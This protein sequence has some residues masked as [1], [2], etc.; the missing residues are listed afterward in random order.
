[1]RTHG[2]CLSEPGLSLVV[3]R[4]AGICI[5]LQ[6]KTRLFSRLSSMPWCKHTVFS[7][8]THLLV[9]F[10]AMGASPNHNVLSHKQ[11]LCLE[12]CVYLSYVTASQQRLLNT[13]RAFVQLILF[14]M[15]QD[16]LPL[17]LP[18]MPFSLMKCWLFLFAS[19]CELV[20]SHTHR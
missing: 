9:H 6:M 5:L 20:P 2:I 7:V 17:I 15:K 1:M 16:K 3:E 10:K 18:R 4:P 13:S 11:H 19:L 14:P 12:S 8:S